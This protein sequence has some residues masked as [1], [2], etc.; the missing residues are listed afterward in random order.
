MPRHRPARAIVRDFSRP[1][2]AA[3]YEVEFDVRTVY[4]FVFSLSDDAGSTD[5]L[6]ARRPGLAEPRRRRALRAQAGDAL[7]VYGSELCVVLAGLAVD[8][9]EVRDAADFV[10]PH[11]DAR[12]RRRSSGRSSPTTCATPSDGPSTER[13]IGRRRGGDPDARGER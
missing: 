11:R 9:P 5:D 8:R 4:D 12:R 13:A 7:E 3:P 6:P 2:D 10:G 1:G